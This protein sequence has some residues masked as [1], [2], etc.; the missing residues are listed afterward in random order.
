MEESFGINNVTRVTGVKRNRLQAWK[1]L[2]LIA[3]TYKAGGTGYRDR[4]TRSDVYW[5]LALKR[6]VESGFSRG[7][8][9]ALLRKS[10][11]YARETKRAGRLCSVLFLRRAGKIIGVTLCDKPSLRVDFG[12]DPDLEGAA[13][14]IYI[15]NFAK[16]R[17]EVDG[18][19]S[20]LGD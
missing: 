14:D 7:F 18:R 15:L 20:E 9:G 16:I 3:P 10:V 6:L 4:W 11:G 2:A 12:S 19:I 8:A 1:D 13:D 17:A 5:V